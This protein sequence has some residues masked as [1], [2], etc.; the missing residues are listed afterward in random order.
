M[1]SGEGKRRE[2]K[3]NLKLMYSNHHQEIKRE[4]RKEES[5]LLL[6]QL[7]NS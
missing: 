7:D 6:Q 3:H 5:D 4:Q 2:V 1:S